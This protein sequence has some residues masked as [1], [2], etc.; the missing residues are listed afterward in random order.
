MHCTPLHLK[1]KI[2]RSRKTKW[3]FKFSELLE[4]ELTFQIFHCSFWHPTGACIPLT[5]YNALCITVFWW[6]P[7][8]IT[9]VN[10]KIPEEKTILII[11]P[12]AYALRYREDSST[13]T[14]M[15]CFSKWS[16]PM[17]LWKPLWWLNLQKNHLVTWSWENTNLP[18]LK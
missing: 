18:L 4:N 12:A 3:F 8:F 14:W 10:G 15:K 2:M 6:V 1:D 13:L 7:V 17:T 11:I 5:F 9:M 16:C